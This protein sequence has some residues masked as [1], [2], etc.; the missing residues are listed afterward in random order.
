MHE[1]VMAM[2]IPP[3]SMARHQQSQS[4]PHPHL[5][6]DHHIIKRQR[7]MQPH[8]KSTNTK[9]NQKLTPKQQLLLKIV[10]EQTQLKKLKSPANALSLDPFHTFP[11]PSNPHVAKLA[12]YC[13]HPSI[14]KEE[15]ILTNHSCPGMG[16]TTRPSLCFRRSCKPI[17]FSLVAIRP[18]VWR[19][20]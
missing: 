12:Q 6:V 1:P 10:Q 7:P 17:H 18:S 9:S 5:L 4:Q 8:S 19:I 3:P 2:A 13:N 20:L 16:G 15:S 14:S 11:I